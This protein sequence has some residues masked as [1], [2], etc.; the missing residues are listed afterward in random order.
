[1]TYIMVKLYIGKL[2]RN[3]KRKENCGR[4]HSQKRSPIGMC[5]QTMFRYKLLYNILDLR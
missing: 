4:N 5:I 3:D 2:S 1:M